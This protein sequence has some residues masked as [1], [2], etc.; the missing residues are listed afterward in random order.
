MT[1]SSCA[2]SRISPSQARMLS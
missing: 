2:Y 1:T